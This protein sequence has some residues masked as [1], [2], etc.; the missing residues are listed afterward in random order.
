MNVK[1][2]GIQIHYEEQGQG[3]PLVLIHGF[4]LNRTIWEPMISMVKKGVR[5]IS[6]DLRGYGSTEGTRGIYGM[7][8]LAEDIASLLDQLKIDRAMVA[9]HSMGGYV[10]L[11]FARAYPE[12]LL[13]LGMIASQATADTPEKRLGRFTLAEEV[14]RSGARPVAES[15]TPK[16]T[17]DPKLQTKLR[18]LILHTSADAIEGS[19]K[20]M[21]E[22]IHMVGYLPEI[23]VPAAVIHGHKDAIMPIERA[24]DTACGLP[25]AKLTEVPGTTGHMPMMETPEKT[26]EALN[27]VL[28]ELLSSQG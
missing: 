18:D 19:L 11:A 25:R 26:A 14:S 22:R 20:G 15:M 17:D 1:T 2:N 24:R 23:T 6:P 3:L 5:I 9:G 13:G 8:L 12:R 28:D 4:P 10:A 7:R 27:Q 21:A 16:L